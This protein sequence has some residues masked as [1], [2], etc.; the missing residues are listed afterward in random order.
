MALSMYLSATG[1]YNPFFPSTLITPGTSVP[2]VTWPDLSALQVRYTV[3]LYP[4]PISLGSGRHLPVNCWWTSG[5]TEAQLWSS[6]ATVS[7]PLKAYLFYSKSLGSKGF[8]FFKRTTWSK[9]T[10]PPLFLTPAVL[11]PEYSS[12]GIQ[13]L[14]SK[15][16][17]YFG[18]GRCPMGASPWGRGLQPG[19]LSSLT[20]LPQ[21]KELIAHCW[22]PSQNLYFA[23]SYGGSPRICTIIQ[24]SWALG[25][26]ESL[27]FKY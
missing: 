7:C 10:F 24:I 13:T 23:F 20:Y 1:H 9:L 15:L 8:F 22:I 18:G 16:C 6:L 14:C 11:T 25:A 2:N 12:T 26:S 3:S 27:F 17:P 21:S 5:L 19:V 4:I